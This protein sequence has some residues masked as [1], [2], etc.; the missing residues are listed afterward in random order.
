[1]KR[2]PPLTGNAVPVTNLSSGWHRP[3]DP[4]SPP[5]R[6]GAPATSKATF[7][8]RRQLAAADPRA[9]A[10][11]D[12]GP[13]SPPHSSGQG[14]SLPPP[15]PPGQSGGGQLPAPLTC[16]WIFPSSVTTQW[17]VAAAGRVPEASSEHRPRAQP[18][19][20]HAR[21]SPPRPDAAAAAIFPNPG[22]PAPPGNGIA[23]AAI[24]G[25]GEPGGR[26]RLSGGAGRGAAP[27]R[28]LR[29]RREP[30]ADVKGRQ[31]AP[32]SALKTF[33]LK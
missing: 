17:V 12:D 5:P 18:E 21:P 14:L 6:P 31:A 26:H 24:L 23:A 4:S 16:C 20:T 33:V 32:G 3:T 22:L 27:S 11:R 25:R 19:K 29:R 9:G 30:E 13:R 28:Y 7:R 15:P 8:Q 2:E 1:M 10:A